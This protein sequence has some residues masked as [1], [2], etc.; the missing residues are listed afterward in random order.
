MLLVIQAISTLVIVAV[1]D[2]LDSTRFRDLP[3]RVACARIFWIVPNLSETVVIP[4]SSPRSGV[5]RNR[6]IYAGGPRDV[7][8]GVRR[9]VKRYNVGTQRPA[10]RRV[11]HEKYLETHVALS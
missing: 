10:V 2:T 11:A 4:L 9:S 7:Q 1:L 8:Y 5:R 6:R 3:P